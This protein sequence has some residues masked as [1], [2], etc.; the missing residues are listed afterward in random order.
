MNSVPGDQCEDGYKTT[1]T[2]FLPACPIA[3]LLFVR[4]DVA[5]GK[6]P[7]HHT[8][9]PPSEPRSLRPKLPSPPKRELPHGSRVRSSQPPPPLFS[10]QN[11]HQLTT[12]TPS[13]PNIPELN[14]TT[15]SSIQ[16]TIQV[17]DTNLLIFCA[18]EPEP[19][20]NTTK[21]T[22]FPKDLHALLKSL[23]KIITSKN[24][25]PIPTTN[26]PPPEFEGWHWVYSRER[27]AQGKDF[28]YST[29]VKV[30]RALGVYMREHGLL[31]DVVW[32]VVH[33][34]KSE[35]LAEGIVSWSDAPERG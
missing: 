4:K 2:R 25:P 21:L 15:L 13:F 19:E 16:Q 10:L 33:S 18:F 26:S 20:T 35:L 29:L 1:V 7:I 11:H 22:H 3:I 30:V 8:L 32:Q 9:P 27:E 23:N 34:Q 17:N 6:S 14:F 31:R 5:Q 24:D 12:H 28:R